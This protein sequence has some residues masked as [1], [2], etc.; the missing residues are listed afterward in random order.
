MEAIVELMIF[1]ELIQ[2]DFHIVE[3]GGGDVIFRIEMQGFGILRRSGYKL[4]LLKKD[5]TEIA[6]SVR[7]WFEF[8]RFLKLQ[9]GIRIAS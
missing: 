6:V 2:F 4:I 8:Q 5:A 3:I 7:V 1:R 9:F